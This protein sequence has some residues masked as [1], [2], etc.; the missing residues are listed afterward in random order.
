[1]VL[2]VPSWVIPGTYAEN[3]AFISGKEG[4]EGVE[5]LFFMY[6]ES[7]LREFRSELSLIESFRNRFAFTA[8]LPDGLQSSHEELVDLLSPLV[9][10]FVVHPGPAGKAEAMAELLVRWKGR[11]GD[12]F[13][14]ENTQDGRF[15]ALE[16]LLPEIPVCLDSGHLL[17]HD[18]SP[19][20]FA[21][22]RGERIGQIHLHAVD[23]VAAAV[24]GRLR[25]HRA[26][27]GDLRWLDELSPFITSFRGILE[28]EVFSWEEARESRRVLQER[29]LV[30]RRNNE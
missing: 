30:P 6:D 8:H 26:L 10:S 3:L 14:L 11:F 22:S 17:L 18:G 12:R 21:D 7:V 29:G 13:L 19:A 2:S 23:E 15:E 4:I 5:L 25:D 27:G 20:A 16:R 9:R 24:D 1:M 28:L